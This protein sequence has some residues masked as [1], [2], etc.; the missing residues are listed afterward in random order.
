[1]ATLS[2]IAAALTG[3]I[4]TGVIGNYLVQRWQ[5]RSW[6][7]QQRRLFNEQEL[8]ELKRLYEQLTYRAEARLTSMRRLLAVIQ[9]SDS[10]VQ[11]ALDAYREQLTL[12]NSA[13]RSFYPTI[14]LHYGWSKTLQ[15][16]NEIHGS[17]VKTG[18]A[19][20][21]L[22]RVVFQGAKPS[23]ADKI[24]IQRALDAQAGRLSAFYL[25]LANGIEKRRD[26]VLNG[27]R[28]FYRSG[29]FHYFSTSDLV[30]ALFTSDVDGFNVIR[31][32]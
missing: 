22:I 15:L 21:R 23:G 16:E 14:T 6:F 28:H 27:R 17:F 7:A 5:R 8:S 2:A 30:K 25:E 9:D 20:E 11:K 1:M 19:L 4:T 13:L 29:S 18:R 26:E 32:A 31:P 12:W 3:A 10:E 24:V